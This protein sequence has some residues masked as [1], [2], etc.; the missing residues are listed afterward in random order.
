MQ[1]QRRAAQRYPRASLPTRLKALA[2]GQAGKSAWSRAFRAR[3]IAPASQSAAEAGDSSRQNQD[4]PPHP[5]RSRPDRRR[6]CL[7]DEANAASRPRTE[8]LAVLCANGVPSDEAVSCYGATIDGATDAG[9]QL[10][11]RD[12][13]RTG[14]MDS[15]SQKLLHE[16]VVRSQ[17]DRSALPGLPAALEDQHLPGK[18][19]RP[20]DLL[21]HQNDGHL[22]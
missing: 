2:I 20:F 6:D 11:P 4:R 1:S 14:S 8:T 19:Q 16:R 17:L 7:G 10:P 18:I 5:G 21:L 15:Q 13:T 3:R 9:S 12:R 22:A